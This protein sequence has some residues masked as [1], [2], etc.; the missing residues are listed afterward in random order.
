MFKNTTICISS[1]HP[2]YEYFEDN[3]IKSNNLY[4]RANF[5]IRQM[6]TGTKKDLPLPNEQEVIN[7]FKDNI[8][9]INKIKEDRFKNKLKKIKGKEKTKYKKKGYKKVN[10]PD[11]K[12]WYINYNLM[13]AILKVTDDYDYRNLP[14][15]TAQKVLRQLD[16][17]WKGYFKSIKDYKINPNKYTGMPKI[18]K[19]RAKNGYN[20]VKFSNVSCKLNKNKL[21]FPNTKLMLDLGNYKLDKL[22]KVE[23]NVNKN[24]A[25][26][27]ITT[28]QEINLPVH[29]S[30]SA[31]AGIDLGVDNFATLT[32]NIGL[33]PILIKG[34]EFKAYNQYINKKI[35]TLQSE[36]KIKNNRFT[37]NQINRLYTKRYRKF[38]NWFHFINNQ[39][40]DYLL[41][42]KIY[43][44]VV[45]KND[46]WKQNINIGKINNQKF[47][48]IPY[49]L[50]LKDLQYKC[51]LNGILY[52]AREESYTSKASLLDLDEIPIYEKDKKYKFSGKRIERGLYKSTNGTLINADVNGS[53]NIIRKEYKDA[54]N[55]I[56]LKYLLNVTI[57]KVNQM[58]CSSERT[59]GVVMS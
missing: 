49:E 34:N 48:Y 33:S 31:V 21:T 38:Y 12:N 7:L 15:H 28:E 10:L 13:D 59:Y 6:M 9:K 46:E 17:N 39:I 22:I 1:K 2:L 51:E 44:L 47:C 52:I 43:V 23:V 37:S 11:S 4:N 50:F 56:D 58:M 57:W 25:T 29:K 30:N 55:G 3:A 18:P 42:N 20:I 26:I 40:I 36:L 5:I 16:D 41:K 35:A 24:G 32:N 8:D 54:F 53:C 27:F 14:I 19:Y 45:G